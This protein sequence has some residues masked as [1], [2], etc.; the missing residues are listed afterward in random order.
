MKEEINTTDSQD[1]NT[2]S[3]TYVDVRE[4]LRS[5]APKAKVPGF[6]VRYLEHIVHQKEINEFLAHKGH[7][8]GIDFVKAVIEYFDLQITTDGLEDLPDG[9]YTFAGNHP[10]GAIDGLSTGL[11]VYNKFPQRG[12]KFLSNDILTGLINLRPVFVPV[13][14]VGNKSQKRSLPERLNEAYASEEQMVIFPAGLCARR[15]KGEICELP[16]AKSF[17][18]KSV[19]FK[20]DVVP[21][22][23]EG[24]NSNFFYNLANIRTTLGIKTNIEMLYLADEL[25]KQKSKVFHIVYGKP[26]PWQYFDT[27]KTQQEWAAWVR[28]QAVA[29]SQK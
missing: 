16:W 5:K 1:K 21:V 11:A 2:N 25:F 17:I 26:I 10:L 27:S 9:R 14:K 6:V 24:K 8:Y 15:I 7:L 4:V 23:F 19:E 3:T 18:Q 28:E 13:N 22:W 12:I 29:L 20:R